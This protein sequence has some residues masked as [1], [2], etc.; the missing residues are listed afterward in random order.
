MMPLISILI[1]T[2]KIFDCATILTLAEVLLN[3]CC[4][5]F[6][7]TKSVVSYSPSSSSIA[8]P[9]FKMLST[10]LDWRRRVRE[11]CGRGESPGSW[12]RSS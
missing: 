1:S 6:A 4:I 3:C 9:E 12:S 5:T 11:R 2:F 10:D 7:L 8:G